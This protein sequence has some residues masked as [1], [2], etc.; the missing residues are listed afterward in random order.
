M[1]IREISYEKNDQRT[2]T[3]LLGKYGGL[4]IYDIYFEKIYSIDD[5][6]ICFVKV[7]GNQYNPDG[8]STY[9]KSFFVHDDLFDI[10]LETD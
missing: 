3:Q 7:I 5:E 9:H 6:D 1:K 10:I 2:R 8:N 4:S